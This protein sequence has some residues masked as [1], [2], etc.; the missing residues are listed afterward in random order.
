MCFSRLSVE[1][2]RGVVVLFV[3][4]LFC[5]FVD[6]L[7]YVECSCEVVLFVGLLFCLCVWSCFVCAI[8]VLFVCV[9]TLFVC[10]WI[11]AFS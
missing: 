10:V 5:L 1:C 6:F 9:D 8:V 3:G 11:L 2:D 7:P 4:L